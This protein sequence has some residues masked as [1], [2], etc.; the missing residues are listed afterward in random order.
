[1]SDD[2]ILDNTLSEENIEKIKV[3]SAEIVVHGTRKEPY[4]EIEY[5]D[6]HDNEMHVGYSSYNLDTVFGYLE[7]Y[8]DIVNDEKEP[9]KR[10]NNSMHDLIRRIDVLK[11]FSVSTSGHRIP[12]YGIDGFPTMISFREVKDVIRK[13]PTAFD[14]EKVIEDLTDWKT[15]AE[16][17]TSKY[18]IIGDT[19]NM[20]LQDMAAR[21]YKNAI[22][23][24]EK[25][26]VR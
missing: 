4:Y 26:G 2:L 24:V 13:V 8:F 1:M 19:D 20:E 11:S 10:Q 17:W 7:K 23:I 14:K 25:G 21:C 6:L 15:D 22:E 3:S 5:F 9:S 16:K 12:E 18:N